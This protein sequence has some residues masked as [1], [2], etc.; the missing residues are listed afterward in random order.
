MIDKPN[1]EAFQGLVELDKKEKS[2]KFQQKYFRIKVGIIFLMITIISLLISILFIAVFFKQAT[3]TIPSKNTNVLK[4]MITPENQKKLKD[5][6][7]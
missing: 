2:L 7:Q 5:L 6:F 1:L 4:E 3:S